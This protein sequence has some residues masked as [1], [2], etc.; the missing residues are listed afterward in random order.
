MQHKMIIQQVAI[1]FFALTFC[2]PLLSKA[3]EMTLLL[4]ESID[5]DPALNSQTMIVDNYNKV[6]ELANVGA[7]L[8]SFWELTAQDKQGTYLVRTYQPNFFLPYKYSSNINKQPHTPT[9]GAA[10]IS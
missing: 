10:P 9:L 5:E 2:F 3:D 4:S 8:N 6:S 7:V 1:L